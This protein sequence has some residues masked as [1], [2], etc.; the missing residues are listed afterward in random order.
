MRAAANAVHRQVS[1]HN[2]PLRGQALGDPVFS[3]PFRGR[4]YDEFLC[5]LVVLRGSVHYQT[6]VNPRELFGETK[7]T[8]LA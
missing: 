4:V 1:H 3:R 7:T 8:E 5:L 6:R 2:R